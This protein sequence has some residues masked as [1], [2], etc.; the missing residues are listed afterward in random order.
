MECFFF[1]LQ[2]FV[3]TY[4]KSNF[5]IMKICENICDT[6]IM[7]IK[8][9]YTYTLAEL[10]QELQSIRYIKKSDFFFLFQLKSKS[11]RKLELY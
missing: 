11:Y 9:N 6:P 5:E 2:E 4:K 3:D 10:T 8:P 1:Q 7:K